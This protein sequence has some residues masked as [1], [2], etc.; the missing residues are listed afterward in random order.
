MAA[1]AVDGATARRIARWFGSLSGKPPT[2]TDAADFITAVEAD[3]AH[4]T[5]SSLP[6]L[7]MPAIV[8]GGADDPFFPEPVLRETAAAIPRAELRVYPNAGHGLPKHHG[9]QLQD[10]VLAF[11]AAT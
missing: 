5:S 6:G 7:D 8:I 3:L 1:A 2:S 4:D 9:K 10:D 11:L